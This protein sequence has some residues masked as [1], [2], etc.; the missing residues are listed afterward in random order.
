MEA[1][2]GL[3]TAVNAREKKSCC[4]CDQCD[5]NEI[6]K[7]QNPA[8]GDPEKFENDLGLVAFATTN[9]REN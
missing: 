2:F 9:V 8:Q 7:A 3:H 5:P 4:G 1:T 6:V